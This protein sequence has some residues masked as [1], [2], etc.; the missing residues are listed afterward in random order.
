MNIRT[1]LLISL[2][3]LVNIAFG[4]N[5]KGYSTAIARQ[6]IAENNLPQAHLV[7][8]SLI[9]LNPNNYELSWLKAITYQKQFQN[10]EALNYF[11]LAYNQEPSD[12]VLLMELVKQYFSMGYYKEVKKYSPP[13]LANSTT[14]VETLALLAQVYF[15]EYRYSDS[16]WYV[17]EIEKVE[18]KHPLIQK[19]RQMI[20]EATAHDLKLYVDFKTDNQ[21]LNQLAERIEMSRKKSWFLSPML[22]YGHL[23]FS[24]GESSNRVV[25]GNQ[26]IFA[27][28]KLSV[29]A[30]AGVYQMAGFN[31]DFVGSLIVKKK[32]WKQLELKAGVEQSPYLGTLSAAQSPI[33]QQNFHFELEYLNDK[34]LSFNALYNEQHF[35]DNNKVKT[36]GLWGLYHVLEIQKFQFSLGYGFNYSDANKNTFTPVK[37]LDEYVAEE[38]DN[39]IEGI[40][41]PYFTPE[42]QIVNSGV[43]VVKFKPNSKFDAGLTANIGIYSTHQNPYF[44]ID[45]NS[46]GDLVYVKKYAKTNFFPADARLF[47]TY[48]L[49][50]QFAVKAYYSYQQTFYYSIHSLGFMLNYKF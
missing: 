48:H 29:E 37:S 18:P 16:E 14:K 36:F 22:E 9:V 38:N 34:N 4:Q 23:D 21:P 3:F 39:P 11:Q 7:L 32:I 5:S 13:L 8:D 1:F 2:V 31:A 25:V 20:K 6:Y 10:K 40:Y 24:T 45:S 12:L 35:N 41:D 43:L 27:P 17:G 15:W 19:I 30:K 33:L 28:L 42:R 44:Y 47:A 50:P 49:S 46:S 26:L